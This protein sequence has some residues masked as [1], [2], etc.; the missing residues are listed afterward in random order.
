MGKISNISESERASSR[1]IAFSIS[2]VPYS[3]LLSSSVRLA[4]GVSE[5]TLVAMELKEG[6]VMAKKSCEFLGEISNEVD[7]ERTYSSWAETLVIRKN[8]T[9]RRG[10]RP[11]VFQELV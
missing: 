3:A 4:D 10:S 7:W 1:A 6:C 9:V 11:Q 5:D 2:T 8:G